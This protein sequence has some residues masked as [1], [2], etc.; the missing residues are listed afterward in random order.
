LRPYHPTY[1][2]AHY[3]GGV[4]E[5]SR[6][7]PG[8]EGIQRKIRECPLREIEIVREHDEACEGC[9]YRTE[10]AGGSVWAARHTCISA[11]DPDIVAEVERISS[12]VF[13]LLNI[14]YGSVIRLN[15][16]VCRLREKIPALD[17]R[18][19]GGPRLREA[20]EKGLAAL[21][22]RVKKEADREEQ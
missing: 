18:M 1:I 7:R 9:R 5:S 11:E 13:G 6:A 12:M 16:L 20:Y 21:A 19:L 3:G 17:Y 22:A 2:V 14:G 10:K 4:P 8:F 15:D